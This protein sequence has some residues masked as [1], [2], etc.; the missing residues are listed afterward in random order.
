MPNEYRIGRLKGR[1][2]VTWVDAGV[3]RRYRLGALTPKEAEA[4]ALDVIRRETL[5]S[6]TLTVSDLW[7]AY[8]KHLGDRPTAETMGYTGRAV[9][10]HFGHFRPDQVTTE[11]CRAYVQVRAGSGIKTGSIWTELGHLRS[12]FN[13]A[14]TKARLIEFAPYVERPEKPAPKERWL[15]HA[16]IERLLGTECEPHIRL[17]C[18]LMLSTAARVGAVLDLTWDRVNLER[19]QIDLRLEA[20]GPRKGRAVVP[21]NTGLSAALTIAQQAAMSNHVIEWA[22]GRILSL[23]T[24]FTALVRASGLSSDVTPHV[25]RHTAGVHMAAGGVAM[26]RIS[27]LM[28]HSNTSVTERV[29]ARYSPDHLRDAAALLDFTKSSGPKAAS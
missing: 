6:A 27:Q 20:I 15:T 21:I 19:G 22:G 13:W 23:R 11:L 26:S 12:C 16:E 28:G 4:E 8:T 9:L 25:L 5:P 14:A 17:A 18:L 24:G 3:R 10:R 29:Y 1:F 7:L 2:V